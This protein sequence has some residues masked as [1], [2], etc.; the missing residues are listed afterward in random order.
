MT[1]SRLAVLPEVA[2]QLVVARA[3]F[4]K[5]FIAIYTLYSFLD[6][7]FEIQE[8][9]WTFSTDFNVFHGKQIWIVKQF[10]KTNKIALLS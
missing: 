8:F 4:S 7:N 10:A 1:S 2:V 6:Y 9:W 5:N 3:S